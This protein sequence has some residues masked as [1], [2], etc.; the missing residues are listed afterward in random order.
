MPEGSSEN[1]GDI[2]ELRN[3][4]GH[5]LA[6]AELVAGTGGVS[7]LQRLLNIEAN[8]G[9]DGT[10]NYSTDIQEINNTIQAI[11]ISIDFD[12]NPGFKDR[13]S[14]LEYSIRLVVKKLYGTDDISVLN[15][16]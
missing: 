8:G 6:S 3:V 16:L 5:S 10:T 11:K 14:A 4:L 7:V 15:T 13:I 9:G 2:V 1:I 12:E